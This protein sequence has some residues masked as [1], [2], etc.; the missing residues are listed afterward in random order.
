MTRTQKNSLLIIL[1]SGIAVA[2][3]FNLKSF[4]WILEALE[5][6]TGDGVQQ[7]FLPVKLQH[8][9]ISIVF[10]IIVFYVI[11]FFNYSWKDRLLPGGLSQ[12]VRIIVIILSNAVVF[13]LF[14][15]LETSFAGLHLGNLK[16]LKNVFSAEYYLFLNLSTGVAAA[17]IGQ[18]VLIIER[19]RSTELENVQLRQEKASAELA[20]LKERIS[21][22]F[23]FNTLNSLSSVI[24]T[25]KKQESLDFVQNMSDVYRYI[26]DSETRN[27]VSLA[28]ELEFLDAYIHLLTKRFGTNLQVSY[29]IDEQLKAYKIPPMALQILFENVVKHNKL[30]KEQPL[31]IRIGTSGET[32][33][34]KNS[35]N[36][37]TAA[38]G[39]GV[40]LA[41]LNKRYKV[42]ADKEIEIKRDTEWFS[43]TLPL[44][45]A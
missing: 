30:S 7:K 9:I 4:L 15:T 43:V 11:A 18:L 24:R 44:I 33:V 38:E 3:L 10:H 36:P 42:I 32:I 39:H 13:Y 26:L 35:L 45:T 17:I 31:G 34:M 5:S 6:G 41:N 16:T 27:T 37:K 21:P 12:P 29:A 28:E 23:F 14:A 19:N 8:G 2:I 1:I 25:E 22:H 20:V 40:G